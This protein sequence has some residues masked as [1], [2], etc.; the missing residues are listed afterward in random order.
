MRL[1][2]FREST[3]EFEKRLSFCLV[4][5][6]G[7][8]VIVFFRLF[9]LQIIKGNY[10]WVF[11]NEHTIKE[12]RLPA[13]RGVIFDRDR[14]SLVENRPSFDLALVP[15]H[16]RDVERV[17]KS[18]Y[19]LINLDPIVI[20]KKWNEIKRSPPYYPFVLQSDIPY[21]EAVKIRV[22]KSVESA[23]P[24]PDDTI[25]LR[26]VEAKLSSRTGCECFDW[27]CG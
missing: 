13:T 7:F 2:F 26:G 9:Y 21:E 1:D 5:T 14:L 19:Q 15:Q 18:L 23:N 20:E 12:I 11:S 3:W 27:L 8:F 10:F 16:L 4:V 6:I 22:A 17:K 25:D 24:L